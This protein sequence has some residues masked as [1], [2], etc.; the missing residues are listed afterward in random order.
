MKADPIAVPATRTVGLIDPRLFWIQAAPDDS[1][2]W[3]WTGSFDGKGY[4]RIRGYGRKGHDLRAHRAAYE[5]V[6]GPI[7]AGNYVCHHC[8]NPRCVRPDHL[9]A[10]TQLDNMRDMAAKGRQAFQR[11]PG[12]APRGTRNGSAKLTEADVRAIRRERQEGASLVALGLR[13]GVNHTTISGIA[14][15]RLWKHIN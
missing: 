9:F 7:P 2:C 13:Y 1:G 15:G 14:R 12:G 3:N 4:G 5:M 10:G 6:N 11:H 8:D